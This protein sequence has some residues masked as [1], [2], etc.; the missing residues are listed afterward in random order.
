MKP[1]TVRAGLLAACFLLLVGRAGARGGA[2]SGGRLDDQQSG[3]AKKMKANDVESL[4]KTVIHVGD[5]DVTLTLDELK[6][7]RT[8][9]VSY[10]K[11]SSYEDRD[12]ILGWSEGPAF[13][14]AQGT[15]RIGPWVLGTEGKEVFLRYREPPGQLAGKAHKAI[16]A[17]KDGAWTVTDLVMERIRVRQ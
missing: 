1:M 14:D 15:A 17:K 10:L 2:E 7:I 5:A 9:L 4:D 16:L 8:A 13:I 6:A 11:A 12:A 3:S